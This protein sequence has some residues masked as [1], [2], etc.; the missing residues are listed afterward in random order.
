MKFALQTM[1]ITLLC[2]K[3]PHRNDEVTYQDQ[4]K[5]SAAQHV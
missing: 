5:E 4:K 2:M 3:L 1:P